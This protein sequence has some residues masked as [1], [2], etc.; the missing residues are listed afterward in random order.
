MILAFP[1]QPFN[2]TTRCEG[3]CVGTVITFKND[4]YY[5][6]HLTHEAG[7]NIGSCTVV[8]EHPAEYEHDP[9][10]QQLYCLFS[11]FVDH[12]G[13]IAL[14]GVGTFDKLAV[15]FSLQQPLVLTH[16]TQ[17]RVVSV[18]TDETM[19]KYSYKFT[20]ANTD[21]CEPQPLPEKET[22]KYEPTKEPT[23]RNLKP[24]P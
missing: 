5:D 14:A 8:A 23:K 4:L 13:E 20:F 6:E 1:P 24:L 7:F 16:A 19:T 15:P 3:S 18:P 12:Y 11:V 21:K 17:D 2:L 22:P 10:I 9:P